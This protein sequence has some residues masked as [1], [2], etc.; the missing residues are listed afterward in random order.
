MTMVQDARTSF[1][2]ESLGPTSPFGEASAAPAAA[3]R[4]TAGFIPWTENL[5]PFME[6]LDPSSEMSEAESMLAAAFAELR[7][8]AFDEALAELGLETEQVISERFTDEAP[9]H[10]AERQRFGDAHLTAVRFEAEQ[11]LDQ[12][13]QGLAGADVESLTEEQ[14]DELLDRFDP[15]PGE[16]TP[17]GE[18]FIGALVRKAKK[19][20][21]FVSTA[22]KT[23]GKFAGKLIGPV[24]QR[25][26]KLINPLLRRVLS[27]AIGRLPTALQGPARAL[28]A[29]ITSEAEEGEEGE[30]SE[31]T[32]ASPAVLTDV[33]SLAESFDAALAEA[34]VAD[35]DRGAEAES[36]GGQ[37]TEE[38]VETRE[39]EALAEARGALIDRL[40][41]AG[42]DE[43]LGPAVE[44][45]IPAL[46]PA[47][48]LGIRLVGRPKVVRFLAGYLGQL[49]GKWVGP[50]LKGP[51]SQAI[52]D[53]GL[54]LVTLEAE[55][56]AHEDE[57]G[58]AVLASVIEDTVRRLSEEE[59]YLFEDEDLLQLA[60]AEAFSRAVSSY[61]PPRLV[62]PGLQQAPT[63]GGAFVARRPRSVRTYRKYSRVPE[64][65][66]TA[67]IVDALPSFGGLTV[68]AGLRAAGARFPIRARVHIYEAA[69]GTTLP[70]VVRLDRSIAGPGRRF[71]AT[72]NMHPL[73]PA[74]AGLLLRE[75]QLGVQVPEAFLRSRHRIAVGQRFYYL[76]PVG[77]AGELAM[78]RGTSASVAA[79]LAPSQGRAVIDLRRSQIAL[80]LYLSEADAQGVAAAMRQGRGGP[81]LLS[82]LVAAYRALDRSFGTPHGRI[83]IVRESEDQEDFIGRSLRRLAPNLIGALRRRLRGWVM[84][85][86]AAWARTNSQDFVRAAANPA[87]GVTILVTLASVPGLDLVRQGL[88]G[89]VVGASS[90]AAGSRGTPSRGAP[91]ATVTVFPGRRRP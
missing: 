46:L 45:F 85:A 78:P 8:E 90:A 13:E 43:D 60:T 48:R 76:E 80:A 56:A 12:L 87:S 72:S 35:P 19:V 36:F 27:F 9:G 69:V 62:R 79:R 68:G 91:T 58:P 15:N 70:R 75:P 3:P 39:L 1:E 61:F 88:A 6:S 23:V 52:V 34:M 41:S 25:L 30:E 16:L 49:I 4:G 31:G 84:P 81:A 66:V 18:E 33:E 24:L 54:R 50:N 2:S 17:A 14:L 55:G 37:D 83:R 32:P 82:A 59:D 11:Y 26:R 57:A 21:K 64:V 89:R 10:A 29:R 38:A 42:E 53:A 65:E 20:V 63:L 73:T 77:S 74:A 7:D 51:L 71:A 44:Q 67:Q 28:A 47:L 22:A 40:A 5:T 86:V